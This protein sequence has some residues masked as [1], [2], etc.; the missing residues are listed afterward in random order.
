M[1]RARKQEAQNS[2]GNASGDTHSKA[3]DPGLACL[4]IIARFH[5]IPADAEQLRHQ[6]GISELTER[7]SEN[8]LLF[9]SSPWVS[10]HVACF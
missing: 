10:R 7:F 1:H 4:T 8:D 9:A 2:T 3:G 5:G 6:S